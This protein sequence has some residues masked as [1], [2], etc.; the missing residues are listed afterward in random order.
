MADR[1][2]GTQ[3]TPAPAAQSK[4]LSKSAEKIVGSDA[5]E[6]RSHYD[7][8]NDIFSGNLRSRTS[9]SLGMTMVCSNIT[10]S[11]GIKL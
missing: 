3:T 4:W 5:D 8:S 11:A 2:N 1:S 9:S 10:P 7:I 6:V